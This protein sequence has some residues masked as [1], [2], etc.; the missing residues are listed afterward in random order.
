MAFLKR[1]EPLKSNRLGGDKRPFVPLL[2]VLPGSNVINSGFQASATRL[3]RVQPITSMSGLKPLITS[4]DGP[5]SKY[6]SYA[7]ELDEK[8]YT[9]NDRKS[10]EA[11]IAYT[12][13]EQAA[14][15]HKTGPSIYNMSAVDKQ[16]V[17]HKAI[18][19]QLM[20]N[21]PNLT[22]ELA[23]KQ[24]GYATG[25]LFNPFLDERQL[26]EF[27][28]TQATNQAIKEGKQS[29]AMKAPNQSHFTAF[30][31]P[32]PRPQS[33]VPTSEPAL[34]ADAAEA[35]AVLGIPAPQ[36][37]AGPAAAPTIAPPPQTKI[38]LAR[39]KLKAYRDRKA[40]PAMPASTPAP[41]GGPFPTLSQPQ[42]APSAAAP[43]QASDTGIAVRQSANVPSPMLPISATPQLVPQAAEVPSQNRQE[44]PVP[45]LPGVAPP[46]AAPQIGPPQGQ[47]SDGAPPIQRQEITRQEANLPQISVNPDDALTVA[48]L[49][50]FIQYMQQLSSDI[51][52]YPNEIAQKFM[53]RPSGM[54]ISGAGAVSGDALISNANSLKILPTGLVNTA[55]ALE[56]A[57]RSPVSLQP[58][59]NRVAQSAIEGQQPGADA[60]RPPPPQV[61]DAA[62]GSSGTPNMA[63]DATMLAD[64][65]AQS[66]SGQLDG[67]MNSVDLKNGIESLKK[68]LLTECYKLRGTNYI[69]S[70]A[71]LRPPKL[72]FDSLNPDS[73]AELITS[74]L[75][76]LS[77]N[78]TNGD[79]MP[80]PISLGTS[81]TN[82][83]GARNFEDGAV[84]GGFIFDASYFLYNT[85]LTSLL[86]LAVTP[87]ADFWTKVVPA[88]QGGGDKNIRGVLQALN[89]N[90]FATTMTALVINTDNTRICSEFFYENMPNVV[91]AYAQQQWLMLD[92]SFNRGLSIIFK[93]LMDTA[94]EYDDSQQSKPFVQPQ[95]TIATSSLNA[96]TVQ[97]SSQPNATGN[98]LGASAAP[99]PMDEVTQ[100]NLNAIIKTAGTIGENAQFLSRKFTEPTTEAQIQFY[101][102]LVSLSAQYDQIQTRLSNLASANTITKESI[103]ARAEELIARRQFLSAVQNLTYHQNPGWA[104]ST[105]MLQMLQEKDRG[106]Q[107]ETEKNNIARQELLKSEEDVQRR[108]EEEE[109]K[110]Q[111]VNTGRATENTPASAFQTVAQ[112]E[113]HQQPQPQPQPQQKPVPMDDDSKYARL[114]S[115]QDKLLQGPRAVKDLTAM[116]YQS[117][118]VRINNHTPPTQRS[119]PASVLGMI[120]TSIENSQGAQNLGATQQGLTTTVGTSKLAVVEEAGQLQQ[121]QGN[122]QQQKAKEQKS[123]IAAATLATYTFSMTSLQE[124]I[125]QYFASNISTL[126]TILPSHN[127][128]TLNASQLLRSMIELEMDEWVRQL[129]AGV[130]N[131]SN[132][133]SITANAGFEVSIAS[134]L[135][136]EQRA[137]GVSKNVYSNLVASDG[138]SNRLAFETLKTSTQDYI[139]LQAAQFRP[140]IA[141]AAVNV[142]S[143]AHEYRH[144]PALQSLGAT[145]VQTQQSLSSVPYQSYNTVSLEP[146]T[147]VSN[148][149]N[150]ILQTKKIFAE[151]GSNTSASRTTLKRQAEVELKAGLDL[152]A[153]NRQPFGDQ[154]AVLKVQGDPSAG[155]QEADQLATM[156]QAWPTERKETR[157]L[158][159]STTNLLVP[160]G[161]P[162]SLQVDAGPVS[163]A[164]DKTNAKRSADDVAEE[165]QAYEDA[166]AAD[167]EIDVG[168][169]P[170]LDPPT[171]V[172]TVWGED[173]GT[174]SYKKVS[175]SYPTPSYEHEYQTAALFTGSPR[176]PA[177]KLATLYG[178]K[179]KKFSVARTELIGE[180]DDKTDSELLAKDQAKLDSTPKLREYIRDLNKAATIGE[181]QPQETELALIRRYLSDFVADYAKTLNGEI[182]IPDF[183]TPSSEA[184]RRKKL[185]A[186]Q[187]E[188][189]V[190]ISQMTP[191]ERDSFNAKMEKDVEQPEF[192]EPQAFAVKKIRNKQPIKPIDLQIPLTKTE[193]A[194]E[195]RM[196]MALKHTS[197]GAI[198]AALAPITGPGSSITPNGA[199]VNTFNDN[200]GKILLAHGL[201]LKKGQDRQ[202]KG[203]VGRYFGGVGNDQLSP[204]EI[205]FSLVTAAA[206]RSNL[207]KL[208][209]D[210]ED[211]QSAAKKGKT[212][213]TAEEPKA[214]VTQQQPKAEEARMDVSIEKTKQNK[215]LTVPRRK[216]AVA[217]KLSE[218]SQ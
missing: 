131:P 163:M 191:S 21:N 8:L 31:L 122:M 52:E 178:E 144:G 61:G 129:T 32:P 211:Q 207:L 57:A 189:L 215:T 73:M 49:K 125:Y 23:Q 151:N 149:S 48:G 172:K 62:S 2:R 83:V 216:K 45:L 181:A 153:A 164:T 140:A 88:L 157:K 69:A 56:I 194:M 78:G 150:D 94:R 106:I 10:Y 120:A 152:T 154:N 101:H 168:E 93:H 185:L 126:N 18:Q 91:M 28:K 156:L 72:F 37:F 162:G 155:S 174:E 130:A 76:T 179:A 117:N 134:Q 114:Q 205:A 25:M 60:A 138:S 209:A 116:P 133:S 19:Q 128:K 58:N 86:T 199:Q 66:G 143:M 100:H 54:T 188:F 107:K 200:L 74:I 81:L 197:T 193:I 111:V 39:A 87:N 169:H 171:L 135:L 97:P 141:Q 13:P 53:P 43:S 85:V 183:S 158:Y 3:R 196:K 12:N 6:Q 9:F 41:L 180:W 208:S 132:W 27:Q 119:T 108:R 147:P 11:F 167:D 195:E 46:M 186:N 175:D 5:G 64:S 15:L 34:Q 17:S 137:Q 112:H 33:D 104:T 202:K 89:Q 110:M 68:F 14:A 214:V 29:D 113:Y 198:V 26:H 103:D 204:Q 24:A 136:A 184:A 206:V 105:T 71:P 166:A 218:F 170:E 79:S 80:V 51:N 35:M 187:A 201:H 36:A 159:T 63:R 145:H 182:C 217:K 102:E 22:S 210:A 192:T 44:I 121:Q 90:L 50:V 59:L 47:P 165:E 84:T 42:G 96:T 75:L 82:I 176:D 118:T 92:P 70:A 213:R 142:A 123:A 109:N 139:I 212:Q 77:A 65:S 127:A 148:M 99:P 1:R 160:Q 40:P 30:N 173:T 7:A 190:S 161:Q 55:Q 95:P 146:D 38:E 4:L 16:T 124:D 177:V 98:L 67:T 20:R 115:E 203:F